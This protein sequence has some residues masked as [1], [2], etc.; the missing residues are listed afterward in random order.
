MEERRILI[1]AFI[2]MLLVNVGRSDDLQCL[3]QA[4]DYFLGLKVDFSLE[5]IV[6]EKGTHYLQ[7]KLAPSFE[8]LENCLQLSLY[9][10]T[11]PAHTLDYE[12]ENKEDYSLLKYKIKTEEAIKQM[13]CPKT[14]E[15]DKEIYSCAIFLKLSYKQS[16]LVIIKMDYEITINKSGT[17]EVTGRAI[18]NQ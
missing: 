13:K 4:S 15:A 6:Q 3:N 2:L 12:M 9:S 7:L 5:K 18:N 16:D 14:E 10:E 1:W 8:P 11:N 17:G